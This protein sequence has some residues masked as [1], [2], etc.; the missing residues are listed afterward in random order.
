MQTDPQVIKSNMGLFWGVDARW[1]P[2]AGVK[3]VIGTFSSPG[4]SN[5]L[6]SLNWIVMSGVAID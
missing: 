4:S 5:S 1:F 3:N 6:E 2:D